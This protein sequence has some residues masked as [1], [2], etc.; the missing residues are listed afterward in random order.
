MVCTA[1]Y[2]KFSTSPGSRLRTSTRYFFRT[3]RWRSNRFDAVLPSTLQFYCGL[4]KIVHFKIPE[5]SSRH[6]IHNHVR[7]PIHVHV[8]LLE[9]GV[10]VSELLRSRSWGGCFPERRATKT[11]YSSTAHPWQFRVCSWRLA[12]WPRSFGPA[13]RE[14]GFAKF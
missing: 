12:W 14:P 11:V 7:F 6:A 3:G 8:A 2:T 9:R 4:G 1:V 13:A 10:T 5:F